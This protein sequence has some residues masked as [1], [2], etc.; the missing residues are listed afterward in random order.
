MGLAE[1]F[2]DTSALL[3]WHGYWI[4]SYR[5]NLALIVPAAL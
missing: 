2:Q 1:D 4:N 3:P 5:D